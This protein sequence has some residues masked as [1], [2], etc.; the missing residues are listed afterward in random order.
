[1][2]VV[3]ARRRECPDEAV[4]NGVHLHRTGFDSLKEVAYYWFGSKSA[5]GRVGGGVRQPGLALRVAM[6]LY[7]FFWKNIFFPDDACLW[8][9][10]ARRTTRALLAAERFDAL[11]SVSLP[12]TGHLVG[13]AAKRQIPDMRW[14]ADMGDPFTI[15]PKPLN[16]ALLY[17]RISQRLERMVLEKADAVVATNTGAVRAYL[18][19]FGE[20][21]GKLQVVPPL[22]RPH[23]Q[24]LP[25]RGGGLALENG[26]NF[27]LGDQNTLPRN[28]PIARDVPPSH[29]GESLSRTLVGRL[30][31]GFFGALYAPT[32]TPDAFLDLLEK[33]YAARPQLR[34]RLAVHFFGDVF[35]EFFEKLGRVPEVRL[36]GLCSRSEAQAAMQRMDILVNI[37][38]TTEYQLPSKVVD[39]LAAGKPVLHLSYVEQDPFLDFWGDTPGLLTLRVRQDRISETDIP[40]WLEFLENLP[41]R[42]NE[43]ECRL[44]VRSF[45]VERLAALY[46]ALLFPP[47]LLRPTTGTAATPLHRKIPE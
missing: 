13:M 24:P 34:S 42:P 18:A 46:E 25:P 36:H 2:H 9:F 26:K 27:V 6:G 22:W 40:R 5:R 16:N 17:G 3:C 8:Y 20:A 39:Y 33:T 47:E 31:L 38:N 19:R 23:P 41:A 11:V 37:G 7:R 14:L 43:A 44:R 4:L 10:P 35:P 32:R 30:G 15:Q 1:V 28:Q 12:F 29:L 45:S 21:A